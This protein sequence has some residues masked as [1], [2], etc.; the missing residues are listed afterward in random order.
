MVYELSSLG[1]SWI[2]TFQA[3]KAALPHKSDTDTSPPRPPPL[4]CSNSPPKLFITFADLPHLGS[5]KAPWETPLGMVTEG[6]DTV[7]DKL[8]TGY[9]DQ[10]PFNKKGIDQSIFQNR[11]NAYIR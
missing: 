5:P 6:M 9:G 7:V 2:Q 1:G 10:K 11:G 8:F 3:C 4:R